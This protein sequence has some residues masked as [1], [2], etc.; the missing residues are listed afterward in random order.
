MDHDHLR[1]LMRDLGDAVA[2]YQRGHGFPGV[3]HLPAEIEQCGDGY[4]HHAKALRDAVTQKD[5]RT[6]LSELV[7]VLAQPEQDRD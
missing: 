1:R 3:E 5:T 7:L 4:R 6:I 2:A